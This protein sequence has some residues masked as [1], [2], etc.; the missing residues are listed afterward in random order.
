MGDPTLAVLFVLVAW[1]SSTGAIL[2]LDRLPRRT[3]PWSFAAV[4]VL[5]LLALWGLA[6]SRHGEGPA[7][8][9]LAFA[10]GLAIWGWNETAFLLGY[11]TGP[12]SAPSPPG[13]ST[14][15]RF[16][17]AVQAILWHELALL[18][19]GAAILAV[20]FDGANRTG[21]GVF[22]ALW[23]LRTSAKLNLH[24]G[25]PN[26]GD[27]LLPDHL[28]HLASFFSRRAMNPLFPLS[29]TLATLA[30]A[31]LVDLAVE[32]PAGSLEATM[33]T[34]LATL[35]ALGLLEHW[36]M[37]LPVPETALWG[38]A[39]KGR[40]HHRRPLRPAPL[41]PAAEPVGRAPGRTA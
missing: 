32:A 25:V 20:T 7:D 22:L 36:L 41:L 8:A 21:M 13:T 9:W 34:L 29:I 23:L 19:S 17:Q 4:S 10:C 15:R 26:P 28:R 6:A 11:V 14:G 12:R 37:V 33:W 18:A 3:F 5:A 1:W 39:L 31:R 30:F 40:D 35:T 24:L 2:W 16:L 27:G 38:W